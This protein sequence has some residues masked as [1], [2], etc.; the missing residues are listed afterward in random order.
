LLGLTRARWLVHRAIVLSVITGLSTLAADARAHAPLGPG[1]LVIV[2][3][4]GGTPDT[5][6]VLA[7]VPLHAGDGIALTDDGLRADGSLRRVEGSAYFDV[8]RTTYPPGTVLALDVGSMSLDRMADQIIVYRGVV[9]GAGALTGEWVWAIG[10][11]IPFGAGATSSGDSALPSALAGRFTELTSGALDMAYVGPTAG[12]ASAMRSHVADPANWALGP[13]G[14]LT[15]STSFEV[16]VDRGGPCVLDGEC[17]SGDFCVDGTCCD[18]SCSRERAG[19]CFGCFFGVADPR[20]GTCGPAATTQLCRAGSGPCDP[21]ETCDGTLTMCPADRRSPAGTVCR[22]ARDGCDAP[23]RCD[24]VE[25]GCPIDE[26]MAFGEVCRAAVG[27]C[28]VEERC[29]GASTACPIDA[30]L[31]D[32]MT[33]EG[34]CGDGTC[35]LGVCFAGCADAGGDAGSDR[36]DAS[37]LDAASASIDAGIDASV[38]VRTDTPRVDVGASDAGELAP[39]DAGTSLDAG[40]PRTASCSVGGSRSKAWPVVFTIGLLGIRRKRKRP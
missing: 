32:G 10:W 29:T 9:D 20:N 15:F 35:A 26:A 11:G 40:S 12:T 17:V 7:L 24:G 25:L 30:V 39:M 19:H 27:S 31:A 2:G 38:L 1:D 14:S 21:Q 23:E 28:D 34:G 8:D 13:A 5:V 33:C 22:A 4:R 6:L 18:T 16:R 36:A 37:M 3:V